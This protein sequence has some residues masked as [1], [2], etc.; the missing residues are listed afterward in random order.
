M[1]APLYPLGRPAAPLSSFVGRAREIAALGALLRR[2][3]VRL[4]TLTGPGGSGKTRLGLRAAEEVRGDFADGVTMVDLSPLVDPD[5]VL[6]AIAR[7]FDLRESGREGLREE[8]IAALHGHHGLLILDNF[9]QVLPAATDVARIV[10]ECADLKV[11]VTSRAPLRVAAE[12][13][14]PVPPL[15]LPGG[16]TEATGLRLVRNP[17]DLLRSDAVDLF[18]QR[19]RLVKPSFALTEANAAMV[20]QICVRLDGLPLAIELAAAWIRLSSPEALLA[21]LT[22]RM[23]L[24]KGGARDAPARLRTMRDAIA[25]SH[26]L[27]SEDE[28][29]LFRRLAAFAGGFTMEAA[30]AVSRETGDGSRELDDR[31]PVAPASRLPSP[32]S[33]GSVLDGLATLVEHSLVRVTDPGGTAEQA[34]AG[35]GARFGMLETIREYALE[36]LVASGEEEEVRRRHRDFLLDLAE[37]ADRGYETESTDVWVDLVEAERHNLRTALRW[38]IERKDAEESLRLSEA[39]YL[40]WTQRGH[41]REAADWFARVL[42]IEP[43]APS[44]RRAAVFDLAGEL[45]RRQGDDARAAELFAGSLAEASAAGDE[46]GVARARFRQGQAALSRGNLEQARHDFEAA[47]AGFHAP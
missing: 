45:A 17:A 19:A 24:L 15:A 46:V 4:L 12:H 41:L 13:D 34:G 9:E 16:E 18:V 26:D 28:Q 7:A 37:R 33:P 22:H 6:P 21:R 44:V 38:S 27:L 29:I 20:E 3:S 25:W 30:E 43:A 10:A 8:L 11:L 2:P 40:F 39:L 5:L 32:D 47:R 31:V 35:G 36:R 23:T 1:V 42:A 14:F